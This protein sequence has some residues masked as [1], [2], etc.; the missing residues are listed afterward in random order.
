LKN[1]DH[2]GVVSQL[3]VAEMFLKG[4][5]MPKDLVSAYMWANLAA[6]R[7]DHLNIA[8]QATSIRNEVEGKMTPAQIAE[9][10]RLAREWKPKPSH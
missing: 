6:A 5:G 7:V 4:E 2:G 8:E 1:A 3:L 10:Q 9:G